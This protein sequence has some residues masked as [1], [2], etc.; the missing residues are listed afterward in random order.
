MMRKWIGALLGSV[1]VCGVFVGEARAASNPLGFYAGAGVGVATPVNNYLPGFLRN[2][3]F[4]WNVTAG[5]RPIPWLGAEVQYLDFGYA[6]QQSRLLPGSPFDVSR[7]DSAH[8]YAAGAFGVAY[9]PLTFVPP[10][11]DLFAK[12]GA[13]RLW[14]SDDYSLYDVT[15]SLTNFGHQSL[16]ETDFAYGGG[17]QIHFGEFAARVE[18][19]A[20]DASSST[21]SLVTLALV[22]TP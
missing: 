7:S 4:G 2:N 22:W 12:L 18:Y 14:S 11:V 16:N 9:L 15:E 19:E 21:P 5:I 13:A 8:S 10:A 1:L 3:E 17:L 20:I 6:R